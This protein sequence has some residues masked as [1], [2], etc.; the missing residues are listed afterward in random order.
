MYDFISRTLHIEWVSNIKN[1][2]LCILLIS[3]CIKLFQYHIF[4]Y[5][6]VYS[7]IFFSKI[8]YSEIQYNIKLKS[9]NRRL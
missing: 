2:F 8:Y 1:L 4:Y 9:N 3:M 5:F 6:I 7:F